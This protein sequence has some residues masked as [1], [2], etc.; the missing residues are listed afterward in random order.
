MHSNSLLILKLS[1]PCT[2]QQKQAAQFEL[3]GIQALGLGKHKN[4]KCLGRVLLSEDLHQHRACQRSG[5]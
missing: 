4:A 2:Q 5:N 3:L 1:P